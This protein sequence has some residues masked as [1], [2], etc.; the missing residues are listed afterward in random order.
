MHFHCSD[1]GSV[2]NLKYEGPDTAKPKE[3]LA[4]PDTD[5][6]PTGALVRYVSPVFIEPCRF[7]IERQTGPAKRMV[8]ALKDLGFAKQGQ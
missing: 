3:Y 8:E 5:K 1:C 7:C 4:T 2:L 6:E